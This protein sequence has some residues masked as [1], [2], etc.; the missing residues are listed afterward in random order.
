MALTRWDEEHDR[1]HTLYPCRWGGT[2]GTR[3]KF[4][5]HGRGWVGDWSP[6]SIVTADFNPPFH[7]PHTCSRAHA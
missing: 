6:R 1:E 7:S 4:L 5:G 2:D 3:A